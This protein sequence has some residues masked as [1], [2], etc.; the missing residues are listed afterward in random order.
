MAKRS[1]Q[2]AAAAKAKKQKIILVVGG[3]LLL[4][5]AAYPGPE[6]DEGRRVGSR[7]PPA[8][9]A[10]AA[11]GAATAATPATDRSRGRRRHGK[12]RRS[13]PAW[14]SRA[15]RVVKVEPSQLVVVQA[16]RGQGSVRA[17]GRRR[18]AD[19]D[20]QPTASADHARPADTTDRHAAV[21]DGTARQLAAGT[22]AAAPPP[23]VVYATINFNG[24]PQQVQEKET[25]PTAEPLFVLVLAEEEAGEDRR[26]RRLVR[27]RQDRHARAGEEADARQHGD[28]RPLRAQARL[29]RRRSPSR[30][31]ASRPDAGAS[32]DEHTAASCLER[33]DDRAATVI[34]NS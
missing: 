13:S 28:R 5:L 32:A 8:R 12:D 21:S 31:R 26:R 10:A 3:V 2:D 1:K 33:H 16:L 9:R 7:R 19:V 25:F 27:R 20:R 15:R 34:A 6:A 30:S 14:R 24:K 11:V 4:G 18:R 22:T 23:P 17:A 29:H